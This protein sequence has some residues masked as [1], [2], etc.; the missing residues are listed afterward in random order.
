MMD[1]LPSAEEELGRK[2]MDELSRII[3]LY[4]VGRITHREMNLM[5]DTLWECVSGLTDSDWRELIEEARRIPNEDTHWKLFG[6]HP[7]RNVF[8][9]LRREEEA[10]YATFFNKSWQVIKEVNQDFS[11]NEN[12][13][14]ATTAKYK[15]LV[16]DLTTKG[17][18]W[19]E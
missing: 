11:L 7:N 13:A 9:Y 1:Q 6:Q 19:I 3:H 16:V 17:F 15:A 18:V 10:F 4:E 8:V 14:K 12:A 5:L 2:A